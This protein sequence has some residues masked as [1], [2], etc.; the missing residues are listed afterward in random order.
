MIDHRFLLG[1]ELSQGLFY[2]VLQKGEAR[3]I[4]IHICDPESLCLFCV[5]EKEED[6]IGQYSVSISL[7]QSV[8]QDF[9]DES[10]MF[11]KESLLERFPFFKRINGGSGPQKAT[12]P[13]FIQPH[14]QICETQKWKSELC[15]FMKE[16]RDCF[17]HS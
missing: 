13:F 6:E 17:T 1:E 15:E 16:Y 4:G 5:E 3:P 14:L 8:T 11:L 12:V 10:W 7:K 9:S 2:R